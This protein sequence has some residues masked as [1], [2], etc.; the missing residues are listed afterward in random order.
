[1]T[2]TTA[3]PGGPA[4]QTGTEELEELFASPEVLTTVE[5]AAE[6]TKKNG[7]SDHPKQYDEM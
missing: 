5:V 2:S 3:T 6:Y 1:M 4:A 7:S